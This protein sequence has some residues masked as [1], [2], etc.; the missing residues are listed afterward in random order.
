MKKK[1]FKEIK[2]YSFLFVYK[3]L[4]SYQSMK[5]TAQKLLFELI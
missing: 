5:K 2:K 4:K 3:P 1:T